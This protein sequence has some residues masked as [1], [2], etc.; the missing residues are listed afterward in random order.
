V[1]TYDFTP[2]DTVLSG[3]DSGEKNLLTNQC[4]VVQRRK[5]TAAQPI[6][7]AAV[8][9]LRPSFCAASTRSYT[10]TDLITMELRSH[11]SILRAN[12]TAL[13]I[14]A[15]ALLPE[16]GSVAVNI[17]TQTRLLDF[18][19]THLTGKGAMEVSEL[20]KLAE[21]ICDARGRLVVK[22]RLRSADG[23][24]IALVVKYQTSCE[25]VEL[26]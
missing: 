13:L 19:D 1:Q 22:N 9:L 16:P 4:I 23:A 14:L 11:F 3:L 12:P 18:A 17:E 8:Y 20:H 5:P 26:I 2:T 21:G 25:S 15:P 7:D 6:K 24:T 10:P